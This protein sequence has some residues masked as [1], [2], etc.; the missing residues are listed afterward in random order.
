MNRKEK[1]INKVLLIAVCTAITLGWGMPQAFA[2]TP[3][4]VDK[5]L[6]NCQIVPDG[7]TGTL[8]YKA[9]WSTVTDKL[10]N[11]RDLQQANDGGAANWQKQRF[12]FV[13]TGSYTSP[14]GTVNKW[15]IASQNTGRCMKSGELIHLAGQSRYIQSR[16]CTNSGDWSLE[17]WGAGRYMITSG[18]FG[19]NHWELANSNSSADGDIHL[20]N[21]H[22]DSNSTRSLYRIVGCTNMRGYGVSPAP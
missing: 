15:E 13:F 10:V 2:A 5:A 17:A 18:P 9:T 3:S 19:S 14:Q 20:T 16:T 4:S 22:V 11:R 21:S 1:K 6:Y 7:R 8:N 12:T